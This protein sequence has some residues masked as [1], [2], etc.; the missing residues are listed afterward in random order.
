MAP[1]LGLIRVKP[2]GVV[3]ES[4]GATA[5]ASTSADVYCDISLPIH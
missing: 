5:L 3:Y 2:R 4:I 1:A